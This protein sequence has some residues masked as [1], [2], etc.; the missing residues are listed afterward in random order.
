MDTS[1]TLIPR[2]HRLT[3]FYR[4]LKAI[5]Y[6]CIF[7]KLIQIK[8]LEVTGF[9]QSI[10]RF[11]SIRNLSCFLQ[12]NSNDKEILFKLPVIILRVQL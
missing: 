8:S 10:D 6:Y 5:D 2:R 4:Q 9:V 7:Q 1:K 12:L 3:Q 11:S